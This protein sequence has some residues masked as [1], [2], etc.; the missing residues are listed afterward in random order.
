M[1]GAFPGGASDAFRD[2]I[3]FAMEMGAAPEETRQATFFF[4]SQL[5]FV[6]AADEDARVDQAGVPFDP[7]V[8]VRRET[9]DPVRVPC[10]IEYYDANGVQVGELGIV[11]PTSVKVLLLDQEHAKVEGC[12]RVVIDGDEYWYRK[13]QPPMGLFDVGIFEVWFHVER[14]T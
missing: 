13:T 4:P 3:R 1:A 11:A 10:A 12:E 14:E 2:G 6:D 5:I 7:S 9:P 8:P